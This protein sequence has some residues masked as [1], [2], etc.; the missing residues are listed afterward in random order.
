MTISEDQRSKK[1]QAERAGSSF[2]HAV[3]LGPA[4]I[5]GRDIQIVRDWCRRQ[6]IRQSRLPS[7]SL[8]SDA[9]TRNEPVCSLQLGLTRSSCHWLNRA[10]TSPSVRPR[11]LARG[12][13]TGAIAARTANQFINQLLPA[14]P[15][16]DGEHPA[17]LRM[18]PPATMAGV[19]LQTPRSSIPVRINRMTLC[20]VASRCQE[21]FYAH[22]I[23]WRGDPRDFQVYVPGDDS[24]ARFPL[25]K[26]LSR[27]M[28]THYLARK[29]RRS[30]N[31]EEPMLVSARPF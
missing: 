26:L 19:P 2:C 24:A 27:A 8:K 5:I 9:Q 10:T 22:H 30:M 20:A 31:C 21:A 11:R 1:K 23:L 18:R 6:S 12:R 4:T 28:Q 17:R 29:I 15:L 7:S 14:L 13:R 3:G 16:L 25:W